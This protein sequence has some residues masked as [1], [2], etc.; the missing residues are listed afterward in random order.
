[1]AILRATLYA[2]EMTIAKYLGRRKDG[3]LALMRSAR[4]LNHSAGFFRLGNVPTCL[5]PACEYDQLLESI[6]E[7]SLRQARMDLLQ[8]PNA[9]TQVAA[10]RVSEVVVSHDMS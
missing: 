7:Y 6:L 5:R 2:S 9:L 1:M 4:T 10:K 8:R 3:T